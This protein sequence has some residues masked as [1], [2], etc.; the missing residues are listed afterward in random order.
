ML[1]LGYDASHPVILVILYFGFLY[2]N[3]NIVENS[4]IGFLYTFSGLRYIN[5]PDL[6]Y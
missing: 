5:I 6:N 2:Q 3:V 1:L 4:L